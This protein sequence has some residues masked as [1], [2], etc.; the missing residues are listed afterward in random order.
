[1][2]CGLLKLFIFLSLALRF[3]NQM[4]TK[5]SGLDNCFASSSLVILSGFCSFSNDSSNFSISSGEITVLRRFLV[6]FLWTASIFYDIGFTSSLILIMSQVERKE[7]F[8]DL[9][10]KPNSSTNAQFCIINHT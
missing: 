8:L 3:W 4:F 9:Q 10:T 1:M 2:F 5:L 7:P 6:R